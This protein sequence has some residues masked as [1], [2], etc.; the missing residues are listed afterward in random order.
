MTDR[1]SVVPLIALSKAGKPYTYGVPEP[2]RASVRP[3]LLV[4]VPFR[5]RI[6]TGVVSSINAIDER[7]RVIDI[8][9]VEDEEPVLLSHQMELAQW[10]SAEYA[11]PLADVFG[12]MLPPVVKRPSSKPARRA[13]AQ[14]VVITPAG[15]DALDESD[16]LSR[17]PSQRGLLSNVATS[18]QPVPVTTLLDGKTAPTA[19]LKALEAR[20]FVRF[21]PI[22]DVAEPPAG[23]P[24]PG[25][26][27]LSGAQAKAVEAIVEALPDNRADRA[28]GSCVFLLHGVTGS[29]KTEVYMSAIEQVLDRGLDAIVMVP[30]ISLTPQALSRFEGRF[31]G[32]VAS[33]HSRMAWGERQDEWQRL[34][35]GRARIAIGPRSALFSPL[36]NVG[37]IVLDEEHDASYKQEES[38]R[39]HARDVAV[40]MARM[41]GIPVILGSATPD[42]ASYY[43]ARKDR[44]RLLTL[45]DRPVWDVGQIPGDR[46]PGS[47]VAGRTPYAPTRA[48]IPDG[49]DVDA[50]GRDRSSGREERHDGDGVGRTRYAPTNAQIADMAKSDSEI[51]GTSRPMPAVE[52]VDLRQELKAGNRSIFSRR[53]LAA[54]EE[55]LAGGRQALLFLNRRGSATSVVCRDC[56]FVASCKACDLPLTFHSVNRALICHRCDRRFPPPKQCPTC[57][58]NRIRYLGVGTQRVAE[59]AARALPDA[60]ILRWDRDV[61]SKKGSHEAI[62]ATFERHDADVLVGTQMIAKGLDFPLVTLVGVIVA[63]VGLNLP[64]FRAPERTFQLMTQVAGRAGRADLPSRVIIQA[65]NPDHYALQAAKNHD[66][67][68][69]YRQEMTFRHASGYP[70]YARLVRLMLRGKDEVAVERKALELRET[71]K[72]NIET[73]R[74]GSFELIGPAPAFTSRVNDV[75]QW[76]LLIRGE[77][78]HRLLEGLPDDVVVDVDPVD[79]L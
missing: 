60:R 45:P 52:I 23:L 29:G 65:Y 20:G 57:G 34:R 27:H 18:E 69:F 44:Y 14:A 32:L 13:T 15:S 61:T 71:L 43:N 35:S 76:H 37:L 73:L 48:Q 19:P 70:P 50:R 38:P 1:V 4:R 26:R 41:L 75:F 42:V 68:S 12:I 21:V 22:T 8:E 55:T 36:R 31:P 30:E 3:G 10:I 25:S 24:L 2:L 78:V 28:Y 33:M 6:V 67:W 7:E 72:S 39:Y 66:Y 58:G 56:G 49:R 9:L 59:E 40:H 77:N 74:E 62:A 64:D 54:L 17:A 46:E 11:A 5:N 53:L 79:L 16:T 47:D 63:D 51:E